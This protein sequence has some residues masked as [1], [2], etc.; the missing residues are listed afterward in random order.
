MFMALLSFITSYFTPAIYWFIL[1]VTIYQ[2]DTK[3]DYVSGTA[4][5]VSV[6]YVFLVL[7][8]IAGS[9]TGKMWTDHAYKISYCLSVIT[10][11]MYGLVIYNLLF[12]YLDIRSGT[13][14]L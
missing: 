8:A 3:D 13:L 6:I 12:I 4:V 7:T 5:V 9:L 1:Y 11:I 10:L 2:I 14:D